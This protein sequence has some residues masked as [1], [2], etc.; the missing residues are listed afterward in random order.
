MEEA[1]VHAVD[2]LAGMPELIFVLGILAIISIVLIKVVPMWRDIRQEQISND[3]AIRNKQLDIERE[4]ELRKTAE[5][6]QREQR[7]RE[8]AE[9][10]SRSIDAQERSTIAIN[11]STAQMA[12]LAAK[13]EISQQGSASM[14][15]AVDD[16]AVEVH[17]IHQVII[18]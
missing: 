4:R 12:V 9:I 5:G 18:K 6:R 1:A 3:A 16:M 14:R 17:D 15:E 7:E 8:N 2:G 11:E 10:M 13:L